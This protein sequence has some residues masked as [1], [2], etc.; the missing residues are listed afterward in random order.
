MKGPLKM[1]VSPV[2]LACAA[3]KQHARCPKFMRYRFACPRTSFLTLRFCEPRAY[4]RGFSGFSVLRFLRDVRRD[5]L[6][7]SLLNDF[8]FAIISPI[9]KF[10]IE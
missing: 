2:H 8:V 4:S 7:S 10:V 1:Y 6:R 3:V 9:L 5:F